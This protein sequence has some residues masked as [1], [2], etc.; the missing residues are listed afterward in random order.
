MSARWLVLFLILI[1]APPTAARTWLVHADGTG[2]APTIQAAIDSLGNDDHIVLTD[3]VYSGLGN[4]D[5]YNSE[6]MFT[7]SSLSGDPTACVI[8]CEGTPGDP[9]WGFILDVGG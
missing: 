5:L 8:D 3:G 1:A 2:D 6:K 7:I 9:H 4:R